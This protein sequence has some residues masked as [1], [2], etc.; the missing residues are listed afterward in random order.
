MRAIVLTLLC[1]LSASAHAMRLAIPTSQLCGYADAVIVGEVTTLTPQWAAGQR[2]GIETLADIHV[3][4]VVRGPALGDVRV[5][6]MGGELGVFV[7][8]AEESP[9]LEL[10]RRYLLL[11]SERPDG[12]YV[13]TGGEAGAFVVDTPQAEAAVIA[14]LG[15]CHAQ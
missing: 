15:A 6:T 10:D 14:E 5:R 11:L 8:K 7:Q 9:E 3:D 2:G 1:A 12:V 4:R 13:V